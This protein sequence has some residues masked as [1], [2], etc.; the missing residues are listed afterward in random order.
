VRTV[1]S[2]CWGG[3]CQLDWL[4][5]LESVDEAASSRGFECLSFG[6][7]CLRRGGE[8]F[9][10]GEEAGGGEGGSE[11]GERDRAERGRRIRWWRGG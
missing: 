3:R 2:V 7:G 6:G 8:G 11:E 1:V 10:W 9:L 4:S 5:K